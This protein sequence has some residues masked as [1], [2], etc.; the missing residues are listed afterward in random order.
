MEFVSIRNFINYID[1]HLTKGRLE[2]ENIHCW[3]QDENIATI[4]GNAAGKIKL[5]VPEVQVARA[6]ELL[7][8]WDLE[9]KSHYSCPKCGGDEVELITN[10]GMEE[11]EI[12]MCFDCGAEFENPIDNSPEV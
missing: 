8:R 1:A 2:Q 3:L 9:R 7:K 4:W 6:T 5:M 10:V 11:K 12:Y